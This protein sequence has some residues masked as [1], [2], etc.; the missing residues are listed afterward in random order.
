MSGLIINIIFDDNKE[1]KKSLK[2]IPNETLFSLFKRY[3]NETRKYNQKLEFIYNGKK[4]NPKNKIGQYD[5]RH[6]S[7]I[8]VIESGNVI[9]RG[10]FGI[11]L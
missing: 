7:K 5:I 2:A 1:N 4:L 3:I 11:T 6:N 9:G 8:T 10:G